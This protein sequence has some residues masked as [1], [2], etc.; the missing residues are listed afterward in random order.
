M[1]VLSEHETR[2][3][4]YLIVSIRKSMT[5]VLEMG[6]VKKMQDW[7]SVNFIN[8]NSSNLISLKKYSRK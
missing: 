1:R 8:L 5:T 2:L 6:N 3:D 7:K 4:I